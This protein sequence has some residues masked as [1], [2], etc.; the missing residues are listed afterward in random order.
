MEPALVKKAITKAQTRKIHALKNALKMPDETYRKLL[1][2]HFYPA[3]SSKQL[4]VEQADRFISRLEETATA[5][6]AWTK[7]EG[8]MT[9][10][11]LSGRAGMASPAQLR[12]IES[13]WKEVSMT[14]RKEDRKKAMR[15]WLMRAFKVSDVRF[16]DNETVKKVIHALL[17][18]R[19]R[20]NAEKA[21]IDSVPFYH[22]RSLRW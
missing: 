11:K 5:V 14:R 9:Y 16:L 21:Q 7:F 12:L 1:F 4:T 22:D 17:A 15:A 19:E 10:E 3:T 18:M 20:K 2:E 13:L 6:G 8:K